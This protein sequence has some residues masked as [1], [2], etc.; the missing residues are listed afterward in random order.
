MLATV[1]R[2]MPAYPPADTGVDAAWARAA[3][4][5]GAPST[6]QPRGR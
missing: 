4:A 5:I 1:P 6:D 2:L 3:D